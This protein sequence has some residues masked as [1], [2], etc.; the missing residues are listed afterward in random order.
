MYL[1]PSVPYLP[2]PQSDP[3]N[4]S[5]AMDASQ[6]IQDTP[7]LVHEQK[8]GATSGHSDAAVPCSVQEHKYRLYKR[9]FSG[10]V[11]FVSLR[12]SNTK[13]MVLR[14]GNRPF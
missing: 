11:G 13:R 12:Q 6:P 14:V 8:D 7:K 3:S 10:I 5:H 9:R 4:L 2:L 1:S